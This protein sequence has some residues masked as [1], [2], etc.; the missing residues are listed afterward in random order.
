[1]R[2]WIKFA[3]GMKG[4][5]ALIVLALTHSSDWAILALAV[6]WLLQKSLEAKIKQ[7]RSFESRGTK[8]RFESDRDSKQ[9][10]DKRRRGGARQDDEQ[11]EQ[12]Q[13]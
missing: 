11:A 13:D 10:V 8:G 3:T 4:P 5:F 2:H 1:M 12:E 6:V 9:R 7:L